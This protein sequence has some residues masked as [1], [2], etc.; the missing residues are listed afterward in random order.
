MK[1][2][3]TFSRFLEH[4]SE[5]KL[6]VTLSDDNVIYFSS[7]NKP[8]P[9]GLIKKFILQGENESEEGDLTEYIPC[10]KVP[11]TGEIHAVVYWKGGLLSYDF[12]LATFNKNGVLIDKKS[13]AGIRSENGLVKKSVATIDEDWLITIVIGHQKEDE[14]MYDPTSSKSINL[15]LMPEGEII[16]SLQEEVGQ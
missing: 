5:E 15:E 1:R 12:I 10:T 4:F 8:L 14:R 16:F 13:I 9:Q 2:A 11:D 7:Q 6:P 3:E